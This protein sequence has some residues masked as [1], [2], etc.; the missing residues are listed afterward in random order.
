MRKVR[1]PPLGKGSGLG[2]YNARLFAEKHH[3]GISLESQPKVG[4]TFHLWFPQ[5]NFTE[6]ETA[7]KVEQLTRHTLLLVGSEA[8]SLS[9]TA[10]QL[11]EHGYYVVTAVSET[12]A[13]ESLHSPNFQFT[14]MVM[15]CASGYNEQLPLFDRV[16]AERL[17][18]K[19]F[20]LVNCNQDEVE[21]SFLQKVDAVLPFGTP[22]PELLARL[23][24]VLGTPTHSNP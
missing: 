18:V 24:S 14:G 2:L 16:H 13:L 17:P 10:D 1:W 8:E 4:T 19:T 21:T 3:A 15:V 11:R 20:C 22:M 9:R 7:Q 12:D 5:A 6:A 23:K